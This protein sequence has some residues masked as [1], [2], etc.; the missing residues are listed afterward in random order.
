MSRTNSIHQTFVRNLQKALQAI[1][2]S[3]QNPLCDPNPIL[4]L[5]IIM[6]RNIYYICILIIN[7]TPLPLL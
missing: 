2:G 4:Q 5:Y 3:Q 7:T 6:I 1:L